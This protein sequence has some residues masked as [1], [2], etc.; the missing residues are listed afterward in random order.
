ML[1]V[2]INIPEQIVIEHQILN[3]FNVAY[4]LKKVDDPWYNKILYILI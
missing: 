4:L 2:I 3:I 1:H